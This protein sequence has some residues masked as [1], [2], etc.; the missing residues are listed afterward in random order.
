MGSYRLTSE[1][2]KSPSLRLFNTNP[3]KAGAPLGAS[4]E[5][6]GSLKGVRFWE[7]ITASADES[8]PHLP[9]QRLLTEVLA[10][11]C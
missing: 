1:I 4:V 8:K 2:L 6:L 3:G 10:A 7:V 5:D 11:Q 9:G